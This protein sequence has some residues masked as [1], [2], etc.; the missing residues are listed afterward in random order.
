MVAL[1][2]AIGVTE[3]EVFQC[4]VNKVFYVC[5]ATEC[6][7]LFDSTEDTVIVHKLANQTLRLLEPKVASKYVVG[8][9]HQLRRHFLC[10]TIVST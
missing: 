8:W 4:E 9:V 2:S 7:H 10:A 1:L 6:F 3:F 5:Q